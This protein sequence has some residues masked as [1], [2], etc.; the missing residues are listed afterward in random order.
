MSVVLKCD[1]CGNTYN[2]GTEK[3]ENITFY[4]YNDDGEG[5]KLS[6]H[7]ICPECYKTIKRALDGRRMTVKAT[8][9]DLK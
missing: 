7:D 4:C 2:Y 5:I 8:E 1:V 9:D 6:S 3:P